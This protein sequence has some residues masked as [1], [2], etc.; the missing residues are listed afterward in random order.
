MI[1]LIKNALKRLSE[2]KKEHNS[3]TYISTIIKEDDGSVNVISR[4]VAR[5]Q[6]TH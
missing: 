6:N 1:K 5:S 4:I 3:I 2:K